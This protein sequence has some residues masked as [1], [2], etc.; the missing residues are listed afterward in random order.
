MGRPDADALT[1][2]VLALWYCSRGIEGLPGPRHRSHRSVLAQRGS[3][4]FSTRKEARSLAPSL[5][6]TACLF[7][8]ETK[9][10]WH[11]SEVA[12]QR[13][14]VGGLVVD[15]FSGGRVQGNDTWATISPSGPVLFLRLQANPSQLRFP[16]TTL[17][18][19]PRSAHGW[20]M[21]GRQLI[22]DP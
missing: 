1:H 5:S 13:R 14:F 21:R 16:V 20:N 12:R 2:A 15:S 22:C 9:R 11:S 19:L 17:A 6:L 3:H 18:A 7:T 4:I 8:I 10:T